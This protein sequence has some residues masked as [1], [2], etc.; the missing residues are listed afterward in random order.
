[1]KKLALIITLAFAVVGSAA[2]A[3]VDGTYSANLPGGSRCSGGLIVRLT[4]T[5]GQ[6][7][8]VVVGSAGSQTI[9]NL[10]LKP[11]GSFTGST[12]GATGSSHVGFAYTVSGQFSGNAVTVSATGG[13]C[14]T[15]T[16]QG[17]RAGG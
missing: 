8:G 17:T 3:A 16:G 15:I 12:S 13:T 9:E 2:A 14:G 10:V 1:V 11:D 7:S 5:R 6:L 4:I